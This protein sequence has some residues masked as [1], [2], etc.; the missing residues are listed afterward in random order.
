MFADVGAALQQL[1]CLH[2]RNMFPVGPGDHLPGGR[3]LLDAVWVT[4][5]QTLTWLPN[6]MA[7]MTN[8]AKCLLGWQ[9]CH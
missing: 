6:R 7:V 4:Q 3:S 2:L 8:E 9:G 1:Y 5:L